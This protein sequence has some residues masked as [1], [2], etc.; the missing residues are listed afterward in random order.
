MT[1]Y[2]R[3]EYSGVLLEPVSP[4]ILEDLQQ[5]CLILLALKYKLGRCVLVCFDFLSKAGMRCPWYSIHK[6]GESAH[7]REIPQGSYHLE[8]CACGDSGTNICPY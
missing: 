2:L 4:G 7:I 8:E 1:F 5:L 3:S 6:K